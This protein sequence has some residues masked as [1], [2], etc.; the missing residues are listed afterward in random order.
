MIVTTDPAMAERLRGRFPFPVLVQGDAPR[1]E[2]LRR[3]RE[4]EDA[5]LIGTGTFWEGIDVPGA[6]LR[7]LVIDKLPFAPPGDPV[8]EARIRA[9]R[10][11]DPYKGKGIRY[12]GERIKLKP[13]KAGRTVGGVKA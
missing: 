7:C 12:A 6:S 11:P 9:I 4:E 13:G 8:V 10:K 2:L 1:G 3:F 5:V